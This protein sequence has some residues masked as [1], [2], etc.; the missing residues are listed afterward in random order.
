MDARAIEQHIRDLEQSWMQ[1]GIDRDRAVP[2]RLL[3]EEFVLISTWGSPGPTVLT[4]QGWLERSFGSIEVHAF[5]FHDM[6]VEVIEETA[7]VETGWTQEATLAGQ[8]WS[9]T[10]RL[11]DVWVCRQ[12]NWQVVCRYSRPPA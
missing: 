12:G 5:A 1:A 2:E 6:S 11:T 7:I 4:K 10:A 9:I 3:A 8:P